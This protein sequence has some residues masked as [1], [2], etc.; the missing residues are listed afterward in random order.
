MNFVGGTWPVNPGPRGPSLFLT[1]FKKKYQPLQH[2]SREVKLRVHIHVDGGK[3]IGESRTAKN[4]LK[5]CCKFPTL[6]NV[7][8][9][10]G[11]LDKSHDVSAHVSLCQCLD[12]PFENGYVECVTVAYMPPGAGFDFHTDLEVDGS[13]GTP[14]GHGKLEFNADHM[15][16]YRVIA[17]LGG[18]N[19]LCYRA[20]D[21]NTKPEH[22]AATWVKCGNIHYAA[23]AALSRG[24]IGGCTMVHETRESEA[25]AESII[26]DVRT[27]NIEAF[28]KE[29]TDNLDEEFE[30]AVP[31]VRPVQQPVSGARVEFKT[32]PSLNR[33]DTKPTFVH[34][35]K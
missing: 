25:F 29:L 6:A 33:P 5:P 23:T 9:G 2:T 17:G 16:R 22:D 11:E 32:R 13:F 24:F 15:M 34:Y 1:S 18:T 31:K 35:F 14:D 7:K 21:R 10:Y 3:L 30:A 27:N 4:A 12:S 28:I 19:N 8:H 26:V 20:A